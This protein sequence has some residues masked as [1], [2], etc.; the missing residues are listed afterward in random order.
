MNMA[1]IYNLRDLLPQARLN[2]VN[3][4]IAEANRDL[5]KAYDI[6][7]GLSHLNRDCEAITRVTR[8]ITRCYMQ[9]DILKEIQVELVLELQVESN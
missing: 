5:D 4:L 3:E 9:I 7:R 8:L 6:L 2:R 1:D